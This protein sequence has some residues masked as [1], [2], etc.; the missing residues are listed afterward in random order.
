[1]RW[2]RHEDPTEEKGDMC[3]NLVGRLEGRRPT[4]RAR[5]RWKGIMQMKLK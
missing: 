3:W 1:M 2:T 4:G 5:P